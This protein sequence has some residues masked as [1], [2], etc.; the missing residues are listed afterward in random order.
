MTLRDIKGRPAVD[1][2]Q[3]AGRLGAEEGDQFGGKRAFGGGHGADSWLLLGTPRLPQHFP[4]LPQWEQNVHLG[5]C[6]GEVG[7]NPAG[8]GKRATWL[9]WPQPPICIEGQHATGGDVAAGCV[10]V[11]NR[12]TGSSGQHGNRR[13]GQGVATPTVGLARIRRLKPL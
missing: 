2:N 7:L 4:D 10:S 12:S 9:A 6:W 1:L 8:S 13:R 5:L 11:K 3:G